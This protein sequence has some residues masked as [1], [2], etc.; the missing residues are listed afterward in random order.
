MPAVDPVKYYN[1]PYEA[2]EPTIARDTQVQGDRAYY[3]QNAPERW[4]VVVF[5]APE[6]SR[7]GSELGKKRVT[8]AGKCI[9][10]INAAEEIYKQKQDIYRPQIY[11]VK[12]IVG[13]PGESLQFVKGEIEIDGKPLDI[14]S[15]LAQ[16]KA[17]KQH[18]NDVYGFGNRFHIPADSVF[19]MGD[20]LDL[21]VVDS[22]QCGP[23][24]IGNLEARVLEVQ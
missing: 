12:R 8:G 19:M 23:I 21:D 24:P 18:P 13:L 9:A 11:Y 17:I 6:I 2:M 14:P 15:H 10:L 1:V 5:L 20:N 3:F 4:D 22:R 7:L 16:Y